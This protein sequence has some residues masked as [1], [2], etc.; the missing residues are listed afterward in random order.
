MDFLEAF[1]QAGL[2]ARLSLLMGFVPLVVALLYT[3]RPSERML[4]IMRPLSLA[5]IFAGIAGLAAGLIV[6]L[7]G[8][9]ASDRDTM[10]RSAAIMGLAES[11]VPILVNFGLL[12]VSWVLVTVGLMRRPRVE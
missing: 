3:Y 1:R 10:N 9:A 2:M 5:S 6:V 12:A 4:A 8:I 7:M 11:F